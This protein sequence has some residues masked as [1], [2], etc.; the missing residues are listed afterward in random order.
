MMELSF[1][2]FKKHINVVQVLISLQDNIDKAGAVFY[3]SDICDEFHF[4]YPTGVSEIVELLSIIMNDTEEW[5]DDWVFELDCGKRATDL[6]RTD[7][8]GKIIPMATVEDLWNVLHKD[9]ADN[10]NR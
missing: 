3:K 7:E 6:P 4:Y 5:I 8:N 9:V 1:E 10:G 2:D